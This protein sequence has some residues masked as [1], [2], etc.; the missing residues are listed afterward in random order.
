[1]YASDF[2]KQ[3]WETAIV[4]NYQNADHSL[5]N[6]FIVLFIIALLYEYCNRVNPACI[7]A[8]RTKRF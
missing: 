1:M 8:V 4:R 3:H 5:K 2:I 7:A 6:E